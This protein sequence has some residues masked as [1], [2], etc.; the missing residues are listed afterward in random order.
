MENVQVRKSSHPLL[1]AAAVAV[2]VFCA[3]GIAAIMGWIPKSGADSAVPVAQSQAPVASPPATKR[4]AHTVE[5]THPLQV[6]SVPSARA[7]CKSCGV[8]QSVQSIEKTGEGSGA[9]A[10]AGGVLGGVVGHQVGDGRGRDLAT[11]VGAVGG[12]FAGHQVEK[13]LKKTHVYQVTVRFDDGS[14]RVFSQA[15]AP[16]W[17]TG[18]RVREDNGALQP[19]A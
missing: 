18:D 1:I 12:A 8:V 16:S 15:S 17:R 10:V 19:E 7:V 5:K 2:I 4:A 3:A 11:V 14:S 9:G 6:A 13:N